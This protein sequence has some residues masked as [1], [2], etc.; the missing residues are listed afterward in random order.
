MM[1][2]NLVY[3]TLLHQL[4]WEA[5]LVHLL[6]RGLIIVIKFRRKKSK[7]EQLSEIHS[8]DDPFEDD[9]EHDQMGHF[10]QDSLPSRSR[11]RLI[12]MTRDVLRV[13]LHHGDILVQQGA[14]LQ[15]YYEVII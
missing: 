13:H 8:L 3:T 11:G 15:K 5:P 2:G 10:A 7:I 6:F 12:K 9:Y 1:T 14:G 4:V